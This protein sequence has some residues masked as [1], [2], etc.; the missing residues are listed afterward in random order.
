MKKTYLILT[1]IIASNLTFGQKL[2]L[3]PKPPKPP[4][5]EKNSQKSNSNSYRMY[6]DQVKVVLPKF[7]IPISSSTDEKSVYYFKTVE[8]KLLK[9]DTTITAE[10]IISLTKFKISKN[11]IMPGLLDSLANQSYKFNEDKKYDET[12]KIAKIVLEDV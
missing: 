7:N 10:Q 1:L 5:Q 4:K 3:P 9:L 2:P 6:G 12:I 11:E 8:E